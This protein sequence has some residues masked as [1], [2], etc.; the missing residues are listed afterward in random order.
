MNTPP[1]SPSSS[2]TDLD[3]E[4]SLRVRGLRPHK[5]GIDDGYRKP[6]GLNIIFES[7]STLPKPLRGISL[8]DA[9]CGTGAYLS[10][11]QDKVGSVT[12]LDANDGMLAQAKAKLLAGTRLEK[13]SHTDMQCFGDRAFDAVITTQVLHHLDSDVED[14]P[15][16]SMACKE[17]ARVLEPG[18]LWII[19]TGTPEQHFCGFW[20]SP[21]IVDAISSCVK[22]FP[23]SAEDDRDVGGCRDGA[24]R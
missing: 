15:N 7:L 9:G 4:R 24:G 17:V 8:L 6:N 21:L 10:A 1:S 22:G 20:W 16:V 13:G 3:S 12:G 2:P 19:S 5:P 14:F 11:I 23:H 18:G